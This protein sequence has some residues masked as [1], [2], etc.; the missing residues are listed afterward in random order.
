MP[1]RFTREN[2][3][4]SAPSATREHDCGGDPQASARAA[5]ADPT[6]ELGD[7]V[8][9]DFPPL[10][11]PSPTKVKCL[12]SPDLDDGHLA[13]TRFSSQLDDVAMG[14]AEERLAERRLGRHDPQARAVEL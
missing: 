12:R 13:K 3:S 10:L 7:E 5:T 9:H 4:S 8:E 1:T 11:R 2:G 14:A 6:N